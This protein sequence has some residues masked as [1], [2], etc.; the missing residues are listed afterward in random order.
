MLNI[1]MNNNGETFQMSTK[2][3]LIE[4]NNIQSVNKDKANPLQI[5]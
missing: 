5:K 1:I 3:T 4:D 2:S